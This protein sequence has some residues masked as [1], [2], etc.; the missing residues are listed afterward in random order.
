MTEY[1]T[2]NDPEKRPGASAG[3]WVYLLQCADDSLYVGVTV[4]LERRLRQHNGELVGGARYTRSRRPVTLLW[5][6][7][8]VSRSEA[9]VLEARLRRL[10]RSQKLALADGRVLPAALSEAGDVRADSR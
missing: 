5:Q 4:C 7:A 9:Q 1:T 3:W 2:H 8:A 10:P 6:K